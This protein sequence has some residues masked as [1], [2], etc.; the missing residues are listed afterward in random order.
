MKFQVLIGI[1][2]IPLLSRIIYHGS[3]V[4]SPYRY[5]NNLC[6]IFQRQ[7]H[8]PVSSPYR[9]SNN[10]RASSFSFYVL[11][12]Q[13]LIGILTILIEKKMTRDDCMFQVLIG[14]LTIVPKFSTLSSNS[15]FKSL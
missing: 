14:I 11:K 7:G 15:C 9:Y 10:S 6:L 12:F 13:A 2:T 5:S 1:L 8:I 4:S 3:T